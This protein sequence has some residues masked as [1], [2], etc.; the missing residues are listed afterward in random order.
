MLR[1]IRFHGDLAEKFGEGPY[2][3]EADNFAEMLSGLCSI[4]SNFRH[5]LLKYDD[6]AILKQRGDDFRYVEQEELGFQFGNWPN[7]H[8]SVGK[9]GSAE[10]A[11]AVAAY[12]AEAGT[13]AYYA[14]YAISYVAIIAAVSYGVSQIMMALSDVQNLSSESAKSNKSTLFNGPDNR[15]NQGG[16]VQ[17]VYGRFQ[18]GSYT[19]SQSLEARR[20]A[21]GLDNS[22]TITE[23]AVGA[24]GASAYF[25]IF[26]ND[27]VDGVT[28]SSGVAVV[29]MIVDGTYFTIPPEYTDTEYVTWSSSGDLLQININRLGYVSVVSME[30]SGGMAKTITV[31]YTRDGVADSQNVAVTVQKNYNYYDYAGNA[32]DGYGGMGNGTPGADGTVGGVNGSAGGDTGNGEGDGGATGTA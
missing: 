27:I 28:S 10:G 4:H 17:L 3:L 21:I 30:G 25:N 6:L 1:N 8:L 19:L 18:V 24:F 14:I 12:F 20:V 32:G 2:L 23:G 16:R 7:I 11:A 22:I 15:E 31:N 5:E 9:R 26:D 29:N 13:A